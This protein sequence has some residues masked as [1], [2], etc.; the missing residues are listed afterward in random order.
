MVD[1]G[2]V[3][4]SS[5]KQELVTLSMMEAEYVTITHAAKEGLWLR[6]LFS[7]VFALINK[8][9]TIFGDNQSAIALTTSA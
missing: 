8:P 3:S 9:T 6:I 2:A 4:W 7:E 1:R 5:K